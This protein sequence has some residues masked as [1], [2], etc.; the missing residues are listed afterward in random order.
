MSKDY[1]KLDPEAQ[2]ILDALTS[3]YFQYCN[4]PYGHNFMGAGERAIDV[5]E[6]YGLAS[7]T[8]GVNEEE[9]DK[10]ERIVWKTN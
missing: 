3:M 7:E 1:T 10:L 2:R 4:S 5:L 6:D 9:M 8:V